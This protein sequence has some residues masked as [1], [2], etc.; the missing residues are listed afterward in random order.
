M[1]IEIERKFL[2]CSDDWRQ[3]ADQGCEYR[4]G[5][6]QGDTSIAVRVRVAGDAA[7]LTIKGDADGIIRREFEY[8]IP[9][10][11]AVDMLAHLCRQ[12]PIEKRRHRVRYGR[13]VW[14]IDVFH[15]TN[16]GLVLAEIE[17]ASANEVFER[18]P[19]LGEEVSTDPRYFNASLS[20]HPY[21]EWGR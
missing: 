4:Q 10:A 17:L 9:V 5:Y 18:P 6:L 7:W 12:P 16:A 1:G 21:R 15:G 13:H 2:L 14:E 11:D 20:R 3:E 19:W 8:P